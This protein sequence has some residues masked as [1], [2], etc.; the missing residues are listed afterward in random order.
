MNW[1]ILFSGLFL[2]LLVLLLFA[3]N[4]KMVKWANAHTEEPFKPG[5]WIIATKDVVIYGNSSH[6]RCTEACQVL[7]VTQEHIV[8]ER[9]DYDDKLVPRVM[10]MWEFDAMGFIIAADELV[11]ISKKES[12]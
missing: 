3:V 2:C 11:S 10:P 6:V 12:A 7:A 4:A 8:I 1:E 9:R 5:D